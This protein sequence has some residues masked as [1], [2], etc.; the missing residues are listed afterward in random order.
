MADGLVRRAKQCLRELDADQAKVMAAG[1]MPVDA[2]ITI[3]EIFDHLRSA[4]DYVAREI[5]EQ[6]RGPAGAKVYFP[7]AAPGANPADF[8]SLAGRMI[9][10]ILGTRE[11]LIPVLAS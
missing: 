4:L 1:P 7:V 6:C 2:Q 11:N 3:K 10:G 5:H 9:S 8:R